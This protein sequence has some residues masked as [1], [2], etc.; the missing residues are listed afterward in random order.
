MNNTLYE[1][2]IEEYLKNGGTVK[3]EHGEDFLSRRFR[4]VEER[5]V[6]DMEMASER[7]NVRS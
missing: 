3:C 7:V 4:T 6:M 5:E 2:E 1:K